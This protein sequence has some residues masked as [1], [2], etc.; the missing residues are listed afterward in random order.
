MVN[1]LYVKIKYISMRAIVLQ[2]AVHQN[3]VIDYRGGN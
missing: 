2:E 3:H 1:Q